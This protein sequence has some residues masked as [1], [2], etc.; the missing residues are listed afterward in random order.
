MERKKRCQTPRN[1]VPGLP[2]LK[3]SNRLTVNARN[4]EK[5]K[6][7]FRMNSIGRKHAAAAVNRLTSNSARF[8]GRP[9]AL[10]QP[11]SGLKT[12]S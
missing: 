12:P 10:N 6:K 5:K 3:I 1:I 9:R 7:Y 8:R 2:T 4:V 11:R